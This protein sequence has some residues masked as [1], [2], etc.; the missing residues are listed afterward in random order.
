[1]G[2]N[3]T[4]TSRKG[5]APKGNKNAVGNRGGAP[6]GNKNAW[7][8]GGYEEIR[9]DTL[10]EEEWEMIATMPTDPEE[11]LEAE[12]DL[13]MIRERRIMQRIKYFNEVK[14]G[15]V[16]TSTVRSEDKRE[17]TDAEEKR[18]Y[19]ARIAAE[20]QKGNRLP[21]HPYHLTTTIEATYNIIQRWEDVLGR[22]QDQMRKA[23]EA[24]NKLHLENGGGGSSVTD[25]WVKAVLESEV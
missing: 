13:L 24:L 25:D 21:G 6:K 18:L 22:V 15:L 1:M 20:M 4:K 7:K 10:T 14:D 5:G 11:L 3:T 2:D 17:F 23:I 19:E 16:V 8:H 12:I 9:W